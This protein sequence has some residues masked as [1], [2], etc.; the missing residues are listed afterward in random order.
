MPSQRRTA[1]KRPASISAT[2]PRWEAPRIHDVPGFCEP[3]YMV[4]EELAQGQQL[5]LGED[6]GC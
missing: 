6:V 5:R 3:E 2:H 1:S 4:G